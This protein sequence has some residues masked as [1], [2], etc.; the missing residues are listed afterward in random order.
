MSTTLVVDVLGMQKNKEC[1]RNLNFQKVLS[2]PAKR[3]AVWRAGG[4][5]C[6]ISA[7]SS[8]EVALG[9]V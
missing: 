1:Y 7:M 5:N 8:E 6:L 4:D 3:A 2:Q 9:R